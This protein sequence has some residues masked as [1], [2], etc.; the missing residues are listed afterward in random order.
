MRIFKL[1][2]FFS[3]MIIAI[4]VAGQKQKDNG[5]IKVAVRSSPPFIMESNGHMSGVSVDLWETIAPEL[6]L[7]YDYVKYNDLGHML[8]DIENDKVDLCINP[9]T[10]TSERLTR[11]SFTQ[12]Y[13]ISGMAIAVKVKQGSSIV[14]FIKK[15]FSRAFIEVI[16]LLFL[17]IFIFGFLIWLVERHKNPDQFGQGIKGLG[18]GIWWSAVTMT[19]VGYGDKAPSSGFGRFISIIWMFTAVIIISSFTASI[20]AALTYNKLRTDIRGLSDLQNARVGTV[21]NSS[22]A[23][24]LSES[25]IG[26]QNFNT[27]SDAVDALVAGKLEAVV[28]DAPILRYLVYEEGLRDRVEMIPSG[29]NS[30]YFSFASSNLKLLQKIN[31]ELIEA[32]DG[33]QWRK[34]LENYNLRLE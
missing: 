34:L 2:L 31:P 32:I 23:S 28:Y 30:V 1:I 20:S 26:Y 11:F 19:T 18:H 10:V 25:R 7:Q 3:F 16:L 8:D 9:L 17:V 27:L 6:G 13:Y 22:T 29:A 33:R 5:K 12:P 14:A 15:L 24:Y 21:R 4:A